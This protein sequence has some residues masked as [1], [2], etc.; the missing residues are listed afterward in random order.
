MAAELV[1]AAEQQHGGAAYTAVALWVGAGSAR[2]A[3]ATAAP[4]LTVIAYDDSAGSEDAAR[5]AA[6]VGQARGQVRGRRA[7]A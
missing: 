3:R 4:R 5:R 6:L 2:L 1:R 7:D